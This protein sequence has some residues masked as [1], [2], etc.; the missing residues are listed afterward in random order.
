MSIKRKK[1]EKR[2]VILDAAFETFKDQ[3]FDAVKLDDIAAHAGV[4]KGTLYLYFKNKED[5]FIKMALDGA[6]QMAERMKEITVMDMPFRE[7]F[8]LFGREVGVFV[9]RRS[10]MFRLMHQI[11]SE[12]IH[13]EFMRQHRLLVKT[14]RALLQTGVNEGLL[15]ADVTVADLHC[16]LIGSLLFRVRL[17]HFNEDR[18]EVDTLLNLFWEAATSEGEGN[19]K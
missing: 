12:S 14:A 17:N 10:L 6:E 11:H 5:L 15:R 8:F 18:I 16:M 1:E 19:R 2:A 7:R 9:A 3:R 13:K 4:G